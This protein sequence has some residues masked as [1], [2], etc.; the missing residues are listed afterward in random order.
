M[1]EGE[2]ILGSVSHGQQVFIEN[3]VAY[4]PDRTCFAG[5]VCTADRLVRTMVQQAGVPLCEAVRMLTATPSSVMG[6]GPK[7][8]N[9]SGKDAD[10][11]RFDD[12]IHVSLT[13][14]EGRVV[15]QK[16]ETKEI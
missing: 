15:Y 7:G 11:V 9:A 12:A 14:V 1:P 16:E 6:W 4:M 5:S 3:G 13:M 2:S 10:L 8:A